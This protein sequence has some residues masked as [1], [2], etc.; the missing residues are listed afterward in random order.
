MNRLGLPPEEVELL[1][2]EPER[3]TGVDVELVMSHFAC[4]EEHSHPKNKEQILR[5]QRLTGA[6]EAAPASLAASS[7]IYLGDHAHFELVR[8]GA[9][10]YGV[11][12]TPTKPNPMSEVVHLQGKILS[13][14]KKVH[15][16][17]K[18]KDDKII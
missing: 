7:G 16:I 13:I 12:P 4:A 9:A 3:L 10:I 6:L 2:R 14:Q 17:K 1:S 18:A 11:N 5:F 8:P 15:L